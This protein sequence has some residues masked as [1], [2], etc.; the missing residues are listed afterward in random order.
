MLRDRNSRGVGQAAKSGGEPSQRQRRVA[1]EV[2]H[3]LADVF[4]RTEFRDPALAGRH[5]T[6]AE[7]RVSPDLKHATAFVSLLG[8]EAIEPLLPALRHAAPFLR[9]EV[10]RGLR[11]RV[12]PDLHFEADLALDEATRINRLLHRPDVLRDLDSK[13]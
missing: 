7:A 3:R 11:L 10:G 8:G 5:I 1:E 6:V 13:E 4:I 9:T 12:T 2:R